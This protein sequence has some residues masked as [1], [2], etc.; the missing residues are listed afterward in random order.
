MRVKITKSAV[1]ALRPGESLADIEIKGFVVRRLPSGT[2]TYGYRYRLGGRQRWLPL[3]LHGRLTAHEA[4]K[5]AKRYAG[6]IASDRDPAAER[7]TA[8]QKAETSVNMLLDLYLDR[9][10]RPNLRGA[11]EVERT[12]H[13]YIRPRIGSMSIYQLKRKR[14][15]GHAGR[16]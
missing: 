5:A 4:R 15:C 11:N 8:R 16:D 1:D 10:V 14:R 12:F 7:Q 3:G 6:E 2:V 9:H 13:K